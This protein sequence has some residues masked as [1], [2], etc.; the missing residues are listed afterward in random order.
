[1]KKIL[2]IFGT[3][4]FASIIASGCGGEE[5]TETDVKLKSTEVKGEL[6]DYYKVIEGSYKLYTDGKKTGMKGVFD[7]EI[8]VQIK[9]TDEEFDYNPVDLQNRGYFAIICDLLDEKGVPVI[10]ADREGM[11]VQGVNSADASLASLKP[12]ETGWA[13]FSFSG[14]K[15]TMNKVKG[16]EV[17]SNVNMEQAESSP[18]NDSEETDEN[19]EEAS[20]VD[21]DQFIEDY[22]SFADSYIDVLKKYK[23]NPSDASILTEYSEAAQ[24]AMEMQKD[25]SSCTDPAY[26]SK[27]MEIA[28]KIAKATM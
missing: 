28:N 8:K 25:A 3:I 16:F 21:C 26:A 14:D 2:S 18:V 10:N 24:K 23:A 12:G 9:R 27:L 15:E 4:I 13:I 22:E 20:D 17:A 19:D 6:S 1:M 11:R 7:Y 5:K